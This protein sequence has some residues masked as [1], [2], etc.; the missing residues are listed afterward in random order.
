MTAECFSGAAAGT[1]L[2]RMDTADA[3]ILFYKDYRTSTVY[4]SGKPIL[5]L[6]T[7]KAKKICS[8]A[9]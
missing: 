9:A 7:E 5:R 8:R 3:P 2:A 4:Y 6:T 1:T